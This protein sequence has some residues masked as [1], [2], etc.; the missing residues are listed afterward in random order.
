MITEMDSTRGHAWGLI[1]IVAGVQLAVVAGLGLWVLVSPLGIPGV[2]FV[3]LFGLIAVPVLAVPL[4]NARRGAR[5]FERA[6]DR[7]ARQPQWSLLENPGEE[8]QRGFFESFQHLEPHLRTRHRGI[9]LMLD[10]IHRE[11]RVV[12]F[13][14]ACTVAGGRRP[15]TIVHTVVATPCPD[16]WPRVSVLPRHP[17][18]DPLPFEQGAEEV[19]F[20]G[21]AFEARWLVRSTDRAFAMALLPRP[22]QECLVESPRREGWEIGRGWIACL[23]G[24]PLAADDVG[25]LIAR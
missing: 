16:A 1:G 3:P 20:A 22:A 2:L 21:A 11:R 4:W 14:H 5:S 6:L 9:R 19:R 12:V 8:I 7:L 13:E 15:R 17:E 10:G 25:L 18:C 23:R 24:R